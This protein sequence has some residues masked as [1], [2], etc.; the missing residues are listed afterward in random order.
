MTWGR[1]VGDPQWDSINTFYKM[2]DRL[3][4]AY[5]RFTDSTEASVS[6]V[7]VAWRYIRDNHPTIQ[8]YS[9]DGSHPSVAGTYLA[10]C[11]FYASLFRKS[12]VGATYL[13]TLDASTAGILQNAAALSVLDSLDF[14]HLRSNEEVAIANFES[15]TN[16]LTVDF[17]NTS[18]RYTE[19]YWTFGD[20]TNSVDTNPQ[21]T[22]ASTGTYTV[23]LIASNE[24]GEDTI[25]YLID[26]NLAALNSNIMQQFKI[27]QLEKGLFILSSNSSLDLKEISI[28]DLIGNNIGNKLL[29]IDAEKSEVFIDLRNH[30]SG[31]YMIQVNSFDQYFQTKVYN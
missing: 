14:W 9:G 30:A 22:Y 12:P 29:K 1:E 4:L 16:N 24:C 2:N 27:T 21:H 11:T 7:G 3:R 15:V 28:Y 17:A 25:Q 23:S 19:S 10:A 13:S 26:V 6:P 31:I 5:L 18:W 8:L 20:G